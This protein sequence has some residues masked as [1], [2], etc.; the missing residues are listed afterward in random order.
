LRAVVLS[1]GGRGTVA[2]RLGDYGRSSHDSETGLFAKAGAGDGI[3][4]CNLWL[5]GCEWS[6]VRAGL[7]WD[8]G[9]YTS[10]DFADWSSTLQWTAR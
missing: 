6:V 9:G 1:I 3:A 8:R 2:S 10:M 7:G 4:G 5:G